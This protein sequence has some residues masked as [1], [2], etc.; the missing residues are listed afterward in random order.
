MSVATKGWR[1]PVRRGANAGRRGA[2]WA[3]VPLLTVSVVFSSGG[4]LTSGDECRTRRLSS[5]LGAGR[6]PGVMPSYRLPG[7]QKDEP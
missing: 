5:N 1:R 7:L 3:M 6:A 4:C 2:V